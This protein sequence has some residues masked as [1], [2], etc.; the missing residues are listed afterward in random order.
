[1][2]RPLWLKVAF[3]E[4]GTAACPVGA[5]NPR[6]T[7]YHVGTNIEG[8]D[9]KVSWC[10]TFVNWSLVQAGFAGTA[11]ALARSWLQ[12]GEALDR[13]V[14]G[15]VAVLWRDDPASWKGHVGFY[16]REDEEFVFLLGG[17]Q[18]GQVREH[19]YPKVMVLGYRWPNQIG[20]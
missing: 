10:S 9:D 19:F 16:L 8:C 17:N 14:P 3:G 1:M 5:S 6:I 18:L 4:L 11:S 20:G 7:S 12:W 15:C 13:P 2:N